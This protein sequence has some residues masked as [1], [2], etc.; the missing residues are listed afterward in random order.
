MAAS[1]D[2]TDA[3]GRQATCPTCASS[4]PE[5]HFDPVGMTSVL[6]GGGP[7]ECPDQFHAARGES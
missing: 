7:S 2:Q 5:V 6:N 3:A 4:Y 1:P